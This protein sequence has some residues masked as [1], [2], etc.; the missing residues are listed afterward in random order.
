MSFIIIFLFNIILCYLVGLEGEK[1]TIGFTK[2]VIISFLL[3][4]LLGIIITR[5]YGKK[6]PNYNEALGQI[7]KNEE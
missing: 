1:R 2:S 6:K 5:M 7:G 4:P 3:T